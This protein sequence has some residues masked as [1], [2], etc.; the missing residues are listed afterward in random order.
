MRSCDADVGSPAIAV[1]SGSTDVSVSEFSLPDDMISEITGC[2]RSFVVQSSAT[3]YSS[4][5]LTVVWLLP[6]FDSR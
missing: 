1:S 5:F 6:A 3:A 2:G 4:L